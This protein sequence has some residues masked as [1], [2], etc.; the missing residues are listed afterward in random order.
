MQI[1]ITNVGVVGNNFTNNTITGKTAS[2]GLNISA[3]TNNRF[4][5]NTFTGSAVLADDK[6]GT[7]NY[8]DPT[9]GIS[10]GGNSWEDILTVDIAD[11]DGASLQYCAVATFS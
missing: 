4:S 10:G 5:L 11:T 1:N 9:L 6:V 2:V 7:N 3:G 8:S